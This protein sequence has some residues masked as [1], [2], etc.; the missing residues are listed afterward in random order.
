MSKITNATVLTINIFFCRIERLQIIESAMLSI[1]HIAKI[2]KVE[3]LSTLSYRSGIPNIIT[4]PSDYGWLHEP[5]SLYAH[6]EQYSNYFASD[7]GLYVSVPVRTMPIKDGV[8]VSKA[9][10]RL[11][12]ANR[13][14]S[15]ILASQ[16]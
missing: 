7:Q 10:P 12:P 1:S 14:R 5:S 15:M 16:Y 9:N 4:S 2:L 13:P 6:P 8:K 11:S 3:H